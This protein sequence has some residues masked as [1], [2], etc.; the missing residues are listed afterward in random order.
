MS[1]FLW[2]LWFLKKLA[3]KWSLVLL[4]FLKKKPILLFKLRWKMLK[5]SYTKFDTTFIKF[6]IT[7]TIVQQ[8]RLVIMFVWVKGRCCRVIH[9]ISIKKS[10]CVQTVA[11]IRP[12]GW[13][14][15]VKI[16]LRLG[17]S[18]WEIIYARHRPQFFLATFS[19]RPCFDSVIHFRFS[20][21]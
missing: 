2:Y 3:K 6:R 10:K 11:L 5:R 17:H 8:L 21:N 1:T 16:V 7:V 20:N 18:E 19:S 14:V 13:G 12:A 4:I 9:I 15:F